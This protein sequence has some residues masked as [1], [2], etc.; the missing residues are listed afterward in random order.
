MLKQGPM[1]GYNARLECM[2]LPSGDWEVVLF[3]T[4]DIHGRPDETHRQTHPDCTDAYRHRDKLQGSIEWASQGPM[5]T[6]VTA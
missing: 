6:P 5:V 2:R 1:A 4:G 3:L